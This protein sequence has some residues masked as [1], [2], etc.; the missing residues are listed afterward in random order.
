MLQDFFERLR[1]YMRTGSIGFAQKTLFFA[2]FMAGAIGGLA[3]AFVTQYQEVYRAIVQNIEFGKGLLGLASILLF[4]AVLYAWHMTIATRQIDAIYPDHADP[5]LDR[6]LTRIR[7]IVASA[8]AALPLFGLAAGVTLSY[9]RDIS[10]RLMELASAFGTLRM[11]TQL[12][13]ELAAL[14]GG[15]VVAATLVWLVS[16]AFLL[17]LNRGWAHDLLRRWLLPVTDTMA[18]CFLASPLVMPLV[19]PDYA[20]RVSQAIGPLAVSGLLLI[21]ATMLLRV[22]LRIAGRVRDFIVGPMA[23]TI[24]LLAALSH[25]MRSRMVYAVLAALCAMAGLLQYTKVL[26]RPGPSALLETRDGGRQAE[27]LGADLAAWLASRRDLVP[28]RPYPV[29]IVA[30]QGGGIYA[31]SAAAM[32]LTKM[33]D[34]CPGFAQHVFAISGV[35]GGAVGAS[36]F[37]ALTAE[38]P[39]RE[40]VTCGKQRRDSGQTRSPGLARRAGQVILQDHLS[41]VL[42]TWLTDFVCGLLQVV[43]PP[44]W[45]VELP[46]SRDWVLERSLQLAF[47]AAAADPAAARPPD[48]CRSANGETGLARPFDAH[49]CKASSAPA[50]LLNSTWA[51]NGYRVAFSPISLRS[52]GDGTLFSFRD[53]ER[54]GNS[55]NCGLDKMSLARAAVVSAR[56]PAILPSWALKCREAAAAGTAARDEAIKGIFVDGGYADNSGAATALE[57]FNGLS[58][59]ARSGAAGDLAR[60]IDIRLIILTD[61]PTAPE[62][63]DTRATWFGDL[64]APVRTLL[65]V[66]A[67]LARR[68]VTQAVNQIGKGAENAVMV[69]QLDQQTFPLTLGWKISDMTNDLVELLLGDADIAS[70]NCLG[71]ASDAGPASNQRAVGTICNNSTQMLRIRDLF[72]AGG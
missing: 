64:A 1:I 29:F 32:F 3:L 19:F 60:L 71:Q 51:E 15:T 50:L 8:A 24:F 59:V 61:A 21:T 23:L 9:P 65:N 57:L 52:T 34:D 26:E 55:L 18:A 58:R 42:F 37:N 39:Q 70:D 62:E 41:P 5:H 30:A 63:Q 54:L 67:L 4:S 38:R 69:V 68:A 66:R 22:L 33:E 56:F 44:E 48:G 31:A 20:V 53:L 2:P 13:R 28:D 35:S 14:Q 46:S 25:R 11:H 12:T 40:K 47:D 17:M 16:V 10:A 6:R 45:R 49:W 36:V 27:P 72:S 7:E 43:V